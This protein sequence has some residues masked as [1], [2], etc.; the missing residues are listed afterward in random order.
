MADA[1]FGFI[2]CGNMGGALA[3]AARK[4]L[5][6]KDILLANR[7]PEKAAALAEKLGARAV[8]NDE[9]AARSDVLFLADKPQMMAN[10]LAGIRP[11]LAAREKPCVLVTLAAVLT[12]AAIRRLAG[13]EFPVLRIMP[14]T[15]AAIGRGRVMCCAAG[16]DGDALETFRT[17][18]AG[19]GALDFVEERLI[20]AGSAVAGCGPAFAAMLIEGL[21]DGG[22]AC[23]LPRGKA[24]EYAAQI[25][26]AHV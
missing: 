13:V 8:N 4:A 24:M 15:P 20:D 23:G 22:V 7:T 17:V 1:I 14:N 9:A 5:E 21:A 19:A 26:R 18:M 11:A 3:T 10:M 2:G 6:G 12:I 25:G 16:V